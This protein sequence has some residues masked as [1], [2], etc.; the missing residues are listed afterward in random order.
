MHRLDPRAKTVFIACILVFC[1]LRSL[2]TYGYIVG[3]ALEWMLIVIMDQLVATPIVIAAVWLSKSFNEMKPI[4]K[5]YVVFSAITFPIFAIIFSIFPPLA[6]EE[7]FFLIPLIPAG[8]PLFE[9]G[10]VITGF[11][12]IYAFV[13]LYRLNLMLTL[14]SVFTVTTSLDDIEVMLLKARL[15]YWLVLTIGFTFRFIPTLAEEAVRITEAQKARGLA[16]QKG[17]VLKRWWNNL[18]PLLVPLLVSSLRKA[19]RFAEALEA[20][21]FLAHKTR[22]YVH[23]L[24]MSR[25]DYTL[26]ILSVT[27]LIYGALN[28]YFPDFVAQTVGFVI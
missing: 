9:G 7:V 17:F 3:F 28:V 10:L 11:S 20:R 8:V 2:S 24:K 14:F 4:I 5:T 1:W 23:Q 15:P 19:I 27:F 18:F 21:A 16:V 13:M 26:M 25:R 22:T 12:C 6:V